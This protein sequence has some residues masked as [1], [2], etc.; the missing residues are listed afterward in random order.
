MLDM[1]FPVPTETL[2]LLPEVA[3]SQPAGRMG[4]QFTLSGLHRIG[5]CELAAN[6]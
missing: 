5:L 3:Y 6:T 2:F 4:I 1:G